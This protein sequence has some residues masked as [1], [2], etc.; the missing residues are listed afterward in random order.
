MSI[1]KKLE[2]I[3]KMKKELTEF[4]CSEIS[5]IPQNTT[6]KPIGSGGMRAFTISMSDVAK[7]NMI[8]DPVYYDFEKQKEIVL[9]KV[10]RS[11]DG[12]VMYLQ[13]IVKDK[14]DKDVRFH[15]EF[16]KSV[17]AILEK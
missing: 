13:K 10:K 8:L 7:N 6:I 17:S 11:K 15:P 3:D 14:K 16:L 9:D 2:E 5:K 4:I 1:S 12:G